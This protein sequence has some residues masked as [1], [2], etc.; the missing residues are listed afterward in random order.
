[1]T[2]TTPDNPAITAL[3]ALIGQPMTESPSPLGRWLGG[4]LQ[5]VEQDSIRAAYT[6]RTDMTNPAGMLHGGAIAAI[7]DDLIG[8]TIIVMTGAYHVSINL[9]VDFLSSA[10]EGETVICTTRI[11][12]RGRQ[13]IHAEAALTNSDGKLIAR[14][15]TNLLAVGGG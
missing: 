5:A 11:V 3:Q 7:I 9:S 10:R 6:I 15:T 12:R 13:V 4:I 2:P 1:M 8:M 14:A